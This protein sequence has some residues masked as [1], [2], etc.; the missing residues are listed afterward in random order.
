MFMCHSV[1]VCVCRLS[2]K[3]LVILDG[4][5]DLGVDDNDDV[6]VAVSNWWW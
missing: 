1:S 3:K 6:I 5:K 2:E 4:D